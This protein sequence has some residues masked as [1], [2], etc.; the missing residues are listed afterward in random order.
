M[1]LL[2][3]M[4]EIAGRISPL[5]GSFYLAKHKGG[6]GKFIGG[7][8]GVSPAKV[9]IIGG[10]RMGMNAAKIAAG[11]RA[12]VFIKNHRWIPASSTD[13]RKTVNSPK[14]NFKGFLNDSSLL[15]SGYEFSQKSKTCC[16]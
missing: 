9:V 5:V 13:G 1:P 10:G 7:V 8:P 16:I 14:A 11:M 12:Q 2:A 3:P 6:S 4:S 15:K